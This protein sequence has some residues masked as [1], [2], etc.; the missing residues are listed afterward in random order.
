MT[1]YTQPQRERERERDDG[2][3]AFGTERAVPHLYHLL[4]VQ[5]GWGNA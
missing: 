4:E 1:V 5:I 2:L 3:H